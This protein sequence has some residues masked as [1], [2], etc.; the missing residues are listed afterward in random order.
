[1]RYAVHPLVRAFAGARLAAA[2]DGAELRERW[3]GWCVDLAGAVGFC[4]DEL[5]RLDQLDTEHAT[6]QAALEWAE[7]HGRDRETIALVEGVR[8]YYNV[9]G[10][11]EANLLHNNARRVAAAQRLGDRDNVVLGLAHQVEILSKQGRIE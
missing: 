3:L 10:F 11:W 8:Y 9:R 2:V 1:R 6:I 4:W 5:D 7:Q